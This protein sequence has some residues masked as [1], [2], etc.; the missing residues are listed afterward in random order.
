MT[1]DLPAV[2]Q[3]AAAHLA[4]P[5]SPVRAHLSAADVPDLIAEVM[6]LRATVAACEALLIDTDG[7]IFGAGIPAEALRRALHDIAF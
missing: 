2:R 3:R 7:T 5:E 4:D 1:V 6:D